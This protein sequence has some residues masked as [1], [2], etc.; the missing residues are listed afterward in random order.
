V[1]VHHSGV[2]HG[3]GANTSKEKARVGVMSGYIPEWMD[4]VAVGWRPLKRSIRDRLPALVRQ[5][6]THVTDG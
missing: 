5:M 6:N 2:W 1:L 4:P 3:F